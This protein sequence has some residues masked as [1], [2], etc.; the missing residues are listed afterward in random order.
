MKNAITL[1]LVVVTVAAVF[2]GIKV[3]LY[4][5]GETINEDYDVS[6]EMKEL[7]IEAAMLDVRI[8]EGDEYKASFK[9]D[10]RLRPSVDYDKSSGKLTIRQE[11]DIKNANIKAD[12]RL[13]IEIPEDN[14]MDSFK[15]DLAMGNLKVDKIVAANITI[16]DNMGNVEIKKSSS[17]SI[18]IE[19][20]MG[21]VDIN[22]C[23]A[24]NLDI[25]AA[26]GNVEIKLDGNLKEYAIDASTSLGNVSIGGDK[27]SGT[28]T[29][30][31]DKG[32]IKVDCNLGDV[33]IR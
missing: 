15:I 6:G 32:L 12:S 22:K 9:G 1:V 2:Y 20:N 10:K 31:G 18:I 13:T 3:H 23:D 16:N 25:K 8:E 24:R 27:V 21:E 17:D 11:K 26:M 29:Q 19:A 28:Y 5:E 33:D 4:D 7:D 30:S 14:K